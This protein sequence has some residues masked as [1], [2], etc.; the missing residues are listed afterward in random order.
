MQE[1]GYGGESCEVINILILLICES[2]GQE[3]SNY[4]TQDACER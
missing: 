1:S 3:P 2:R 4:V